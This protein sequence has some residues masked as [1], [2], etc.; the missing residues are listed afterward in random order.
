MMMSG[1]GIFSLLAL[2]A[3]SMAADS[4]AS[5][6]GPVSKVFEMLAELQK[7]IISEG[8]E[9]QKVY[10]EFSEWCKD[11][12]QNVGFE[13]QSGKAQVA[14]LMATIEKETSKMTGYST[15]IEELSGSIASNEADL[16]SAAEIRKSEAGD[17][18][19]EEKELLDV[20]STL[21]RAV[22]VLNREAA[23]GS[24]SMLQMKGMQDIAMAMEAMVHASMLS[25]ADAT[26]L[27]SLVQ[28]SQGSQDNDGDAALGAP[29]PAAYASH[30]NGIIGT[31]EDLLDK[32]EAQLDKARKT[33]VTNSHNY[34]MLRQ[35]LESEIDAGKND[36]EE[37]KK[38]IAASDEAKSVAEGD[39]TV[40]EADLKEDKNTMESLHQDC[41]SGAEDFKAQ[42]KS[43][44]DELKALSQAKKVLADALPAAAQTYGAALDQASFLQIS[45]TEQADLSK[46][47]AVRL[48]RDLG[49][50]EQSV[51]LAQLASRMAA[52]LKY[53]DKS[54]S[55]PFSKVKSLIS[56]M[57]SKLEKDAK[58]DAT[59]KDFCEKETSETNAKKDEKTYA[60][61]KLATKIDSMT[62]QSAKL[63]ETVVA[64]STELREL[65][66]A[67]AE[68]DSI[69]SEESA[70]YSKNK[71]EMEAG[72]SGVQ[73]ALN[74]LRDYYS[75]DGSNQDSGNGIISMLEVVE[76]DFTKGL[77]EI[78]V[79]ES[80]AAKEYEKTSYMNKVAKRSK[81][82]DLE[83]KAKEAAALDKSAAEAGSDKDGVQAELDALF[84]YL[85]KLAKM[86]V[87]KA[88]PYA[89]RDERRQAEIAGL[90]NA[91]S[92][93]EGEAVLLQQSSSKRVLRGT[94][95][96]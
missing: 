57:I 26:R 14:D 3:T 7:K 30:S 38:S 96:E 88:E 36:M 35:S 81:S 77:T 50:K 79:A 61:N 34:D 91:L 75:K 70:I 62:A 27:T 2:V 33:E 44:G 11:R 69:R 66:S 74:V 40:T 85:E 9:A 90:K 84:E 51:A 43:R 60:V 82:K 31:L 58:T 76:S 42:T 6:G 37:A 15:K 80:T 87:A 39:L 86:C 68:M 89:K 20:I 29:D 52:I 48:I 28:S 95:Q 25:S 59:H 67:Q 78:E 13:I 12:S 49:R 65:A 63:K 83:Y 24:A 72:I 8:K 17:F 73:K 1:C 45:Q 46:F 41:M 53:G 56:D 64:L 5:T 19:K 94:S 4:S 32:A 22:G 23:K 93:L 21:E 10:D 92:I 55:D 18:A 71:A 47:E 16:K 54:G